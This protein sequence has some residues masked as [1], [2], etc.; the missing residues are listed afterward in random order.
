MSANSTVTTLRSPSA[1][2]CSMRSPQSQQNLAAARL[3]CWQFG[4]MTEKLTP[5]DRQ[6][7]SSANVSI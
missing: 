5:H 2:G 3:G 6:I 7:L 1:C 4:Q